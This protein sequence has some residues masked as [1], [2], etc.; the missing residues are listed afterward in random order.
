MAEDSPHFITTHDHSLL[1]DYANRKASAL[2]GL[3]PGWTAGKGF[4][5]LRMDGTTRERWHRVLSYVQSAGVGRPVELSLS[6][7]RG[8]PLPWMGMCMP[9]GPKCARCV[10]TLLRPPAAGLPR[11]A[12]APPAPDANG[13]SLLQ[14][15]LDALPTPAYIKDGQGRYIWVNFAMQEL[16]RLPAEQWQGKTVYDIETG[17][18]AAEIALTDSEIMAS[19]VAR[20]VDFSVSRLDGSLMHRQSYRVPFADAGGELLLAGISLDVTN[21]VEAT[22]QREVLLK[23]LGQRNLQVERHTQLLE[24]VL[25]NVSQGVIVLDDRYQVILRNRKWCEIIGLRPSGPAPIAL[26]YANLDGTIVPNE[27]RPYYRVMRGEELQDVELFLVRPD[28]S[29]RQVVVNG[30][31]IRNGEGATQYVIITFL[32]VTEVRRLERAREEFLRILSHDLR[33]P[34]AVVSAGAQLIQ[35]YPAATEMASGSAGRIAAAARRMSAMIQDLVES[36]RL[37]AGRIELR[38]QGVD[39]PGL[40]RQSLEDHGDAL[41]VERIRIE[42]PNGPI[43][44]VVDPDS[45]IRALLN[46]VTNALKYSTPPSPVTIRVT[47]CD[48]EARVEVIDQGA[49]M[50]PEDQKRLFEPYYRAPRAAAGGLGLGLY[51]VKRLIEAHGGRVWIESELGR[52]TCAGFAVPAGQ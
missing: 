29:R 36:A 19:G 14:L 18:E 5:Q 51:I 33:T 37:E 23:E 8:R 25:N 40:V 11:V 48:G 21:W 39:L 52:G 50:S 26:T 24:A 1:L 9:A 4:D 3:M 41:D 44:A 35:Q 20:R 31:P 12:V 17:G 2:L 28:G 7:G 15:F 16:F 10:V 45:I 43:T 42:A 47:A 27:E 32:D 22:Q 34:L 49:G 38:L 13:P 46:L 30:I 6:D